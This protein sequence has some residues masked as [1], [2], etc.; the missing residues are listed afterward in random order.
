MNDSEN[1]ITPE[2]LADEALDK[3]AGGGGVPRPY[4]PQEVR[5]FWMA[6]TSAQCV[7]C[8][9]SAVGHQSYCWGGLPG[10]Y[11]KQMQNA[12]DALCGN[13]NAP[14]PDFKSR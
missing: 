1:K 9:V 13:P 4:V 2:E 14:C 8:A 6:F 10:F 3:V 11:E 7:C 5:A 12:Y